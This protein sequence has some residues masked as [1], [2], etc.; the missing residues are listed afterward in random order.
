[1]AVLDI[2]RLY[3]DG[4][5]LT[6]AQLDTIR[7]DIET[8]FNSTKIDNDNIQNSGLTASAKLTALSV[9]QNKFK[10]EAVTTSKIVDEAVTEDKVASN[11]ATEDKL[12]DNAVTQAKIVTLFLGSEIGAVR[13][14]QTYNDLLEVPRGWMICNGEII[15]ETN[16]NALHGAGAFATDG[17][18]SSAILLKYLPNMAS[19]YAVGADTTTQDGATALTT[20]GNEDHQV[21]LAHTHS[22]AAAHSHGPEVTRLG[23]Y[24]DPGDLNLQGDTDTATSALNSSLSNDVV[25]RPESI[26]FLYIMRVI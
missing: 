19:C 12:A 23:S 1:M 6:E 7:Q 5:V 8:F 18:T 22:Y 9:T 4:E 24:P 17:I 16:Y 3:S 21:D 15:N 25:I 13:M 10:D 14:F 2:S 26:E 20:T 11:A